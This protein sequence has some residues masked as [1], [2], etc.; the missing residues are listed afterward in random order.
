MIP[1]TE[2]ILFAIVHP[3]WYLNHDSVP[4]LS[5]LPL[6]INKAISK[7]LYKLEEKYES[8][9]NC[10]SKATF[11]HKIEALASEKIIASKAPLSAAII[12]KNIKKPVPKHILSECQNE[13]VTTKERNTKKA[14]LQLIKD[15]INVNKD[16]NCSYRAVAVSLERSENEWSVV[17]KELKKELNEKKQFYQSIFLANNDYE[18]IIKEIAWVNG[19]C[20]F[21]Y[22]MRMLQMGDVIANTYQRLL[23]FFSSQI[24]L[25]FL[26]HHQPLNRNGAL[27]IAFINNNHYVALVLKS[28]APVPLI[29]N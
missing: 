25:I 21:E 12:D 8:L 5:S 7:A 2:P 27:A 17:R 26:S 3:H 10:R 23:Y 13:A 28:D 14:M 11:L 19:P 4:L 15:V 9:S 20:T 1:H 22:W 18:T 29:I 24:N 16:D 6:S